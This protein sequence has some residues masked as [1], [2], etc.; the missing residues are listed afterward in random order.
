MMNPFQFQRGEPGKGE[1]GYTPDVNLSMIESLSMNGDAVFQAQISKPLNSH[2]LYWR[3]NTLSFTDGWNWPLMPRDR[4]QLEFDPYQ[5]PG[6]EGIQQ[7]I[8]VFGKHDFFFGLDHPRYYATSQGTAMLDQ[9]RSLSIGRWENHLKYEILSTLGDIPAEDLERYQKL[10]SGLS[11]EEKAWIHDNFKSSTLSGLTNEAKIFFQREGFSYSLSPGRVEN[12]MEFMTVK[13]VGFC[14]HYASALALILRQ[15][16]IP[17]RL[18]SGFLGGNYNRFGDFYLV[19]QNDAHVWVEAHDA[20]VW[21]R[22]DPTDWIV[23]DR[24]TLGGEAFVNQVASTGVLNRF[25]NFNIQALG[26]LRQWLNQWDF[27]FYQWLEEMDY[28][29]QEAFLARWNLRRDWIFSIIPILLA[30]FMSLYIWHLNRRRSD[31]SELQTV[32]LELQLHLKRRG[33]RLEYTSIAET[34]KALLEYKGVDKTKLEE[35]WDDLIQASF[36]ESESDLQK[37]RRRI[38]EL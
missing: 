27:R 26:E 37:L 19:T 24:I 28:Y 25:G 15:K 16:K 7:K 18:V 22:L 34:K 8:R 23:P 35:L 5:K 11:R 17:V 1:I 21:K 4:A 10:S 32:W 29:G 33:I 2:Q 13:K 14:S 20:G 30:L 9:R 3:G 38:Q 6:L 31:H 36:A 12:F